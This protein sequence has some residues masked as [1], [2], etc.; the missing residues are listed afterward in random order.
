[1]SATL[2][3]LEKL[4]DALGDPEYRFLLLEPLILY[5]ILFGLL[6]FVASFL[7][8]QDRMQQAALAVIAL[9]A[10]AI[11]PYTGSRSSA[12][13]R[14]EQVY[15]ISAPARVETFRA[16]TAAWKDQAWVYYALAG[17]AAGTL[18]IGSR[19]NRLGAAL[20]VATVGFAALGMK[21][22]LWLHYQ[23]SLAYHPNLKQHQAPVTASSA[24]GSPD[25]DGSSSS[26]GTRPA[27]ES[28]RKPR[29]VRE[30][31]T[32]VAQTSPPAPARTASHRTKPA[33]APD[34]EPS[35]PKIRPLSFLIG[36]SQTAS[37]KTS[38]PRQ[39][40]QSPQRSAPPAP[41]PP[42]PAPTVSASR[43]VSRPQQH[44]RP[45]GPGR[46]LNPLSLIGRDSNAPH[47][48]GNQAPPV[49]RPLSLGFGKKK[50]LPATKPP[51]PVDPAVPPHPVKRI[52]RPI[53]PPAP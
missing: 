25:R 20:A 50:P 22:A 42:R 4:L 41:A 44:A 51:V 40:R 30:K 34:N 38:A 45:S 14:V 37:R 28:L 13:P 43:P 17:L 48:P 19:R 47:S 36:K 52:S 33:A 24:G 29:A 7:L 49:T 32:P 23:D 53:P 9:S 15:K 27:P 46:L 6:A 5:G 8:R 21:D 31:S 16:N 18:L 39:G 11:L 2:Q 12:Q 1:M 10:L 3:Q 35:K 26:P